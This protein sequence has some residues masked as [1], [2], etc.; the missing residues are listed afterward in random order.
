M[1]TA[2]LVAAAVLAAIILV[3]GVTAADMTVSP[4][5]DAG[6]GRPVTVEAAPTNSSAAPKAGSLECTNTTTVWTWSNE[7]FQPN[8]AKTYTAGAGCPGGTAPT[9]CGC[10]NGDY[11]VPLLAQELVTTR[12]V[13]GGGSCMCTYYLPAGFPPSAGFTIRVQNVCTRST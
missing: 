7:A 10:G 11:N 1:K 9:G 3:T 4:A 6:A 8:Q 13:A 2:V 5:A 12:A